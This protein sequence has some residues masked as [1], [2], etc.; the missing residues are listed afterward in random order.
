MKKVFLL[1]LLIVMAVSLASCTNFNIAGLMPHTCA[2]ANGDALCDTCSKAVT[3][4]ACTT[5]VDNNGDGLCDNA[6]CTASVLKKMTGVTFEDVTKTYDGKAARITVAGAPEGAKINYE[7]KNSQKNA[8]E[9]EI[10]ATVTL[11]GY[12][13][14]ELTATLTIEPIELK[15]K[16][17]DGFGPFASSGRAPEVDYTLDGEILEGEEVEAVFDFGKCDF[18]EQKTGLKATVKSSNSNYKILFEDGKATKT[19]DV[20]PNQHTVNFVSGF[21]DKEVPSQKVEDSETLSKPPLF[22]TGYELLG[23]YNGDEVWDFK[24]PVTK[25]ITLTAK[26]KLIEYNITYYLNGGTNNSVNPVK[27]T[28]EE[29]IN[30]SVPSREGKVFLG[31]YEDA[32]YNVPLSKTAPGEKFTDVTLYA[33]WADADYNGIVSADTVDTSFVL[34]KY[35]AAGNFRYTFAANVKSFADNGAIYV[36]RGRDTLD[37][38]YVMVTKDKVTVCINDG[39]PASDARTFIGG[40][41]DFVVIDIVAQNNGAHVYVRT[42]GGEFYG[43]FGSF[44]GKNGEIFASAE[45]AELTDASFGW[46]GKGFSDEVWILADSNTSFKNKFSWAYNVLNSEYL[47]VLLISAKG[48]DSTEVLS[49]FETALKV[50]TPKY[51]MWSFDSESGADYDKNLAAFIELCEEKGI[52]PVLTTHLEAINS[53]N[54][55]KN[56]AVKALLEASPEY[57]CVDFA[58]LS[59]YTGIYGSDYTELGTKSY[60]AKLVADFPEILSPKTPLKE[61]HADVLNSENNTLLIGSTKVKDGKFMVFTAKIN[62]TLTEEQSIIIGHGYN[63]TY[64]AWQVINGKQVITYRQGAKADAAPSSSAKDH[65]LTIKNYITVITTFDNDGVGGTILILTDGGS[66]SRGVSGNACNG[67]VEVLVSGVELTD[68]NAYWTSQDYSAPIWIF[69]ASY[70]SLDDPARW[71]NYMYADDLSENTLIVGRG[72]LNSTGGLV[73]LKDALQHG[74]PKYIIWGYGMNDGKDSAD[75]MLETTYN[76]HIEFLQI[77]KDKGIE[78]IFMSSV[79]CTTNFHSHKIDYVLNR[80]GDFANY[81]YR[82]ISLPHAVNGYEEGSEWY[83]GMLHTDGIH[84][85]ALGARN[86]YLETLVTFPEL[87]LGGEATVKSAESKS[88]NAGSA[89]KV[90]D[91]PKFVDGDFAISMKADFDG[92]IEGAIEIGNGKG[93]EGGTWAKITDNTVEVYTTLGG[94]DVLVAEAENEIALEDIVMIRIIVRDNKANIAFVSSDEKSYDSKL[95]R[96]ALF[97]VEAD[98]SYAGEVFVSADEMALTDVLIN[99]ATK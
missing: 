64:S 36:G 33:K 91:S 26:W 76:N 81:D 83:S 18:K 74:T 51:A 54:K 5:H 72:G 70:F 75:S 63:S 10:T 98:W 23:W 95:D 46:S 27:Y 12:E 13:P 57:K 96:K 7:P 39:T 86:F 93:V 34:D 41:S 94:K 48:A 16:L 53:A 20:G 80:K 90:T 60:F 84:P 1:L 49:A 77:C 55:E 14:L 79:N 8:G 37:G 45:N 82:V 69:G 2:D 21:E 19:F 66:Y 29:G 68:A 58:E 61:A 11:D 32:Y 85:T 59:A 50:N 3:P 67:N 73:E 43:F 30:V 62:G 6:G 65:S 15:L 17:T 24:T 71:P 9:Y 88:L 56:E 28:V 78:A 99:L 42:A 25:G 35:I 40:I 47:D 38:S 87:M 97:S 52:V 22:V 31:W 89:L 44:L 92:Y 4:T